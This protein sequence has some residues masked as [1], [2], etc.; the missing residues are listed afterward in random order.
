MLQNDGGSERNFLELS[1]DNSEQ[2]H[3][4]RCWIFANDTK[5]THFPRPLSFANVDGVSKVTGAVR[6]TPYIILG[7]GKDRNLFS[8]NCVVC[9][10]F[11]KKWI[12]GFLSFP[13]G[14]EGSRAYPRQKKD[15]LLSADNSSKGHLFPGNQKKS[16]FTSPK[17]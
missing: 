5:V 3:G 8:P 1:A 12:A 9:V 15:L 13:G 2:T 6:S 7:A 14:S 16:D 11:S 10:S 4:K 17:A